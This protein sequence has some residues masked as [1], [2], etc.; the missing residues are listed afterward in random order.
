M[1][2]KQGTPVDSVNIL[3]K[4]GLL[5]HLFPATYACGYK[6]V[7]RFTVVFFGRELRF[8][9]GWFGKRQCCCSCEAEKLRREAIR[10]AICGNSILP[11]E[12]VRLYVR[13]KKMPGY[14]VTVQTPEGSAVVGCLRMD[15]ADGGFCYGGNWTAEG[16]RLPR[17]EKFLGGVELIPDLKGELLPKMTLVAS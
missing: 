9:R 3:R 11:G 1:E 13:S 8:R 4:P 12:G 14:A 5:D 7:R 15:C 16:V 17:Q 10:C 6:D 2:E